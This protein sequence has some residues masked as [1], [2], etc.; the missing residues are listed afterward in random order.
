MLNP[1]DPQHPHRDFATADDNVRA[2][3]QVIAALKPRY[4][5]IENPEGY[6]CTRPIMQD[7]EPLRKTCTYCMY[8][9]AFRKSTHIWTNAIL[10]APLRKCTVHT[11]CSHK[12][13]T[14]QHPVTAQVGDSK[15]AKGSGSAVAVYPVPAGLIQTLT[16]GFREQIQVDPIAAFLIT[17]ICEDFQNWRHTDAECDNL[18]FNVGP[19]IDGS[20][21]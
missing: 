2:T 18:F 12:A 10:Q 11:P 13:A 20:F 5:F 9:C 7:L 3:R 17:S 8:G 15:N 16:A 1:L 4:W 19:D 21:Y 6:L 14:G